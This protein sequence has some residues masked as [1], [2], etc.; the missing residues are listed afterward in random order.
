[1]V[2]CLVLYGKSNTGKTKTLKRLIELIKDNGYTPIK[3]EEER[4]AD[5]IVVFDI[6][7]RKVGITSRGDAVDLLADDFAWMG[8]CDLY[9]CAS[10]SR[11]NTVEFLEKKFSRIIW[12]RRW[13]VL[14]DKYGIAFTSLYNDS[15]E[16][17]A[18]TLY[19][20]ITDILL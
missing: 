5:K 2:N 14:Q 1:M 13:D 20:L 15:N 8:D 3:P 12:Q 9:V 11:G 7:G 6:K 10:H 4:D 19:N 18:K 16:A 17:Q